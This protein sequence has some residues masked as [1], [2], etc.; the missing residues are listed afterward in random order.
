MFNTNEYFEG[1]VKS[2]AFESE[3]GPATVGVMAPGEYEFGTSTTE[4]MLVTSGA[5][6]VMQPGDTD[7]VLCEP[8]ESFDVESG[9]RFRV[10]VQKTSSYICRYG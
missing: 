4:N 7:W 1:K 3:D 2:L 5:L 9:V 8:G 10:R 6:E